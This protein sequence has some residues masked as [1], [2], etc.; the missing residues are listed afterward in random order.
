MPTTPHT[1]TRAAAQPVYAV[2]GGNHVTVLLDREQTGGELDVIE[3]SAQPGG[4]PPPHR[5]AFAEWFR[6]L[7]GELTIYE[8]RDGTVTPTSVLSAGDTLW[9]PPWTVHATL[10]IGAA[11]ARFTVI[12]RPGAM[13]GYLAEAGVRVADRLSPPDR[14]PAGP[15]QLAEISA[16][17]GIEFWT[18]PVDR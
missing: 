3:V 13:S 14:E 17:W 18:G 15:A 4:G 12:S 6:L 5:H 11:P 2:A 9:I 8:D 10:N 1:P 16:R 7:E